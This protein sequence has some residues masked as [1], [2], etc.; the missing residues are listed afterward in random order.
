MFMFSQPV[1]DVSYM[2]GLLQSIE[3]LFLMGNVMA[4]VVKKKEGDLC[5]KMLGLPI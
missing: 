1:V 3:I 5:T 2:R 4:F